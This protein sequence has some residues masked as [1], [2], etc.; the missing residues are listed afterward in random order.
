[1]KTLPTF[2]IAALTLL[3]ACKKDDKPAPAA[4]PGG[5]GKPAADAAAKAPPPPAA[6]EVIKLD[7]FATPESFQH[8][9]AQDLYLVSNI[10]GSPVGK[11]DNGFISRVSP[12]GKIVELKWI[13]GAKPDV[14]L[15]APKGMAVLD[16]VLYVTDIDTVRRFDAV[17]GAPKGETK[18]E[19]ATFL[20]DIAIQDGKLLVTDSGLQ[21]DD[22]KPSGADAVHQLDA[23]GKLLGSF[24]DTKLNK[25][26]GITSAGH[27]V[28]FGAKQVLAVDFAG[29]KLEVAA[30]LPAG[31]LDGVLAL[32]PDELAVASW[33]CKCVFVGP[34]KG[35]YAELIKD[36]PSPADIGWDA[37]RKRILIPVF[38]ENRVE[39]HPR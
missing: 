29:K 10:N 2:G 38:T 37:Q 18:I 4:D 31:Q 11:D 12:E 22:F 20:N 25:P 3:A 7:G 24:K 30:E 39:I 15:D 9:P 6:P 32:G 36:V 14:A 1:M 17:T 26:N 5:G 35:P 13:D 28:T 19:G 21:G 16:G 8:D 33:E 34:V 23:A 27:V